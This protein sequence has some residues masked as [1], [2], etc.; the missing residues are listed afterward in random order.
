MFDEVYL[1]PNTKAVHFCDIFADI[2][3]MFSTYPN[4]KI[5]KIEN[6]ATLGFFFSKYFR[7]LPKLM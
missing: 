2:R 4:K 5:I 6:P 7:T 3:A 1:L